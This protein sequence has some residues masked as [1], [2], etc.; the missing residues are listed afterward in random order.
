MSEVCKSEV[1]KSEACIGAEVCGS[2][3]EDA[4]VLTPSQALMNSTEMMP[5][6]PIVLLSCTAAVLDSQLCCTLQHLHYTY[7]AKSGVS[8]D[9]STKQRVSVQEKCQN[10]D[11]SKAYN[12][13]AVRT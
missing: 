13:R 1:C 9:P 4:A 12:I 2:V 7:A 11:T 5:E 10:S 6:Q 3:V 8:V